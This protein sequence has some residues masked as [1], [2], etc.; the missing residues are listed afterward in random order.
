M[1]GFAV[2]VGAS[3][4]CPASELEA[5]VDGAL[6]SV[7]VDAR[8][9]DVLASVEAKRDEEAIQALAASH[10]WALRFYVAEALATI[11][12]PTPSATVAGHVG[13]PSVAEAS[14]LL[15]AGA[16][17]R[18]VVVKQRSRHATCA[19]ARGAMPA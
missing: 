9:V 10:G 11:G 4:G 18:L 8:D 12:V 2:G 19:I 5:L 7:G 13:T 6:A 14:A 1:S 16:R 15:A 17:A 3:R